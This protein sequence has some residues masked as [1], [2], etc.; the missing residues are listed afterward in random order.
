MKKN[1]KPIER[2]FEYFDYKGI[3]PTRLEKQL[4]VSNGYF[5]TQ[6]RRK[7]DL[8]SSVIEKII[9]YC[10][11]LDPV[12]LLTGRG[13]MLKT[14]SNNV[15]GSNI[16]GQFGNGTGNNVN[17]SVNQLKEEL[18]EKEEIRQHLVSERDK[19]EKERRVLEKAMLRLKEQKQYEN[20]AH[21]SEVEVL[22]SQIDAL[23][24]QVESLKAQLRTQE[25][26]IAY[27]EKTKE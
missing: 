23:R 12:W 5:G 10:L 2:L 13:Q 16:V 6:K 21:K 26:L 4:G 25:K 7:A 27:M 19:L 9:D 20:I 1:K 17:I 11:D 24:T 15:S 18:E 22:R 3:K 14:D 8:G